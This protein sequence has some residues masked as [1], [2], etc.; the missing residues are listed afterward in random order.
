MSH[1]NLPGIQAVRLFA[2]LTDDDLKR[3]ALI[4]E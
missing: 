4:A 2:D 1:P 3:L